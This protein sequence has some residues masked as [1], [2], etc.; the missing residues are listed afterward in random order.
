MAKTRRMIQ[1]ANFALD[2]QT[3]RQLDRLAEVVGSNRSLALRQ[4]I[5]LAA[6]VMLPPEPE[7]GKVT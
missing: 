3:A 1:R 2:E 7:G 5:N 6:S 4:A